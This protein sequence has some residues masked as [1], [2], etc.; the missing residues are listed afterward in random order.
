VPASH[1]S[2][3][4]AWRPWNKTALAGDAD[5]YHLLHGHRTELILYMIAVTR[6][7]AV[8]KAISKYYNVLRTLNRR[9]AAKISLQWV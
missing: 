7:T 9:L 8:K 3:D 1:R 4:D 6:S 5:L 2:P